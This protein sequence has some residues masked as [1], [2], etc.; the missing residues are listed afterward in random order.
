MGKDYWAR[1]LERLDRPRGW[2]IAGPGL[3]AITLGLVVLVVGTA[4]LERIWF[5]AVAALA[6]VGLLIWTATALRTVPGRRP[7]ARTVGIVGIVAA[8][9]V[10]FQG[11]ALV[12]GLALIGAAV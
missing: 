4:V 7:I 6:Q 12:V 10:V 2:W 8:A 5:L 11:L 9:L 3:G 1:E